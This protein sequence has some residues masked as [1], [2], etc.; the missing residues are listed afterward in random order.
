MA[1]AYSNDLR[2]KFLQAYD[3]G[4]DTLEELAEQFRVSLGWAKKISARRSRTGEV[5]APVWRH[6][7]VSRVTPAI[8]EWIRRQ[9]C[10]RPDRT[11]QELREQLEE[12]QQVRLSMGRMW[13][14]LRQLGLPLKKKAL[15]AQEQ[16]SKAAQRRRQ[17]WREALAQVDVRQLIFLDE[18]GA[19]T[20]MTRGY[21][22]APRGQRVQEATPQGRWQ[23]LT[24]LAAL[25]TRGS[26]APMTITAPTDGD[27][28]LAYLQQVLCPRLRPGQVVILDNLSAHKVAGVR[29]QIE[30][31]GARLFYLPP[32]SP[33]FNPIEQAW[34]KV[35]QVLRSLKART[36]D[37][38][39]TA[40]AEAL[41]AITPENAIASFS[42][43][44]YSLQ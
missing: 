27:I 7:P 10:N 18:S 26:E 24:M 12:S 9:I 11:L 25:T 8:Q 2:R 21:A 39:E 13:L 28:F 5:D 33:D 29:E 43:C 23:T 40:V 41:A 36:A 44:G 37:A 34:S 42:H 1:R 32:Y 22:R 35:K 16:D 31:A 6:G 30:A 38:L 4:E 19:S 15:H 14:A 3:E 20:Q 17:A